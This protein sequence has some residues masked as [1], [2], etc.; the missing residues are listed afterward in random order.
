[1]IERLEQAHLP[2]FSIGDRNWF[3]DGGGQECADQYV[4]KSYICDFRDETEQGHYGP[5]GSFPGHL[6]LAEEFKAP[7]TTFENGEQKIVA[8]T[9]DVGFRSKYLIKGINSYAYTGEFDP[10]SCK[11]LAN[12][13]RGDFSKRNFI[14][15]HYYIGGTFIVKRIQNE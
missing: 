4:E 7:I 14:S 2:W 1:M 15:D 10:E 5:C 12:F 3:A 6:E 11:L 8:L 13:E 9:L